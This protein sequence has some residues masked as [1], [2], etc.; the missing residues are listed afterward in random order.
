VKLPDWA[1]LI[2][3]CLAAS[4]VWNGLRV[5]GWDVALSDRGPLLMEVNF[6]ADFDLL[7]F[8]EGAGVLDDAWRRFMNAH[9][10]RQERADS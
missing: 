6:R 1:R 4:R 8:A 7:Q 5:Q 3:V 9:R 2:D 10:P